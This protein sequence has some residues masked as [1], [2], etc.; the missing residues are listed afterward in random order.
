MTTRRFDDKELVSRYV[1]SRFSYP[2]DL[3][4][5]ILDYLKKDSRYR[6]PFG[7]L[8]DV[9][10]GSGQSTPLFADHFQTLIGVDC[11]QAQ[12]EEA[13]RRNIHENIEYRIGD[14][15]SLPMKDEST[16]LVIVSVALHWFD[17]QKFYAEV[18]RILKP[19]GLLAV[20]NY[21]YFTVHYDQTPDNTN[22]ITDVCKKLID[23]WFSE[24]DGHIGPPP[25]NDN[26]MAGTPPCFQNEKRFET[27][28]EMIWSVNE[29][30]FY[31]STLSSYDILK[32]KYP[33]R[34]I[35]AET[36]ELLLEA[37]NFPETAGD[38]KLLIR[39]PIHGLLSRKI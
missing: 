34:D 35:S 26:C 8:I 11:S 29:L 31:T 38:T 15:T 6:P 19:G 12:I 20:W 3:R 25:K 13:T 39:F 18:R 5:I 36:K 33:D 32:A 16:D 24:I 7:Q 28:V 27:A 14:S 1:K 10:C 22:A 21:R 23:D 2:H 37:L 4:D 17:L 9:G 30:V